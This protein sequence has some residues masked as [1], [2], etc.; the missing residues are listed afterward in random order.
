MPDGICMRA[1]VSPFGKTISNISLS[2]CS[3]PH[4]RKSRMF[5]GCE[6]EGVTALFIVCC[7]GPSGK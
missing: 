2:Q 4:H 1:G 6:D 3:C 5:P 7:H